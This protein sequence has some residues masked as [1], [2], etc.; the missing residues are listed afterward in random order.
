MQEV[1][2]APSI[3]TVQAPQSP[4]SQPRFVP[5]NPTSSRNTS[6]KVRCGAKAKS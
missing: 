4:P 3:N 1:I 6:S 5:V 2:G